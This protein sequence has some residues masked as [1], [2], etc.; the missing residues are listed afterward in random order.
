MSTSAAPSSPSRRAPP[1]S[2]PSM[3][4][5]PLGGNSRPRV[6]QGRQPPTENLRRQS[7]QALSSVSDVHSQNA[8]NG[9]SPPSV[10]LP[11]RMP[12][13]A[14]R[15]RKA[16]LRERGGATAARGH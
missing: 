1:A 14:R 12:S 8:A 7:P 3:T 11:S 6:V 2:A 10:D 4:R 13:S 9:S 16:S 5:L 15:Q